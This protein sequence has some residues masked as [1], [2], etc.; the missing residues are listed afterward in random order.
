MRHLAETSQSDEVYRMVDKTIKK[1]NKF[2]CLVVKEQLYWKRNMVGVLSSFGISYYVLHNTKP[3][4]TIYLSV[5]WYWHWH[6]QNHVNM[7]CERCPYNVN[8][9]QPWGTWKGRWTWWWQTWQPVEIRCWR[10][11]QPCNSGRPLLCLWGCNPAAVGGRCCASEGD[12]ATL[13]QWEAI[14]VPLREM[15]TSVHHSH[16]IIMYILIILD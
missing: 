2:P 1:I 16:Y 6:W 11:L 5:Y 9:K 10:L 12:S 14:A 13:Q 4:A 8:Q 7:I 3:Y 15:V